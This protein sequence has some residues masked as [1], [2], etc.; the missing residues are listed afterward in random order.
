M[1]IGFIVAVIAV[2]V[3]LIWPLQTKIRRGLDLQ[4]GIHIVLGVE[5]PPE[6]E[7]TKSDVTD[8]ALEIIRNRI[9]ALGVSEP[10]IQK[11]GTD[12]IIVD[13]PGVKD[14]ERAVEIIGK[15]ALLE[16]RLVEED[17]K[18]LSDAVRG[19]TI[20]GYELL[21]QKE[22]D[23]RGILRESSPL[24][25]KVEPELTGAGLTEAYVG[26]DASG[27]PEVNLEFN[28]EGAAKFAQVTG[29]NIGRRLAIVLDGVVKSA[30]VI[31]DRIPNGRAQ[32]SGRFSMDEARELAIVLRAGALPAKVDIIYRQSVGP[33]LGKEY[34]EKS[35][36]ASLYG[37]IIVVVFMIVYYLAFGLLAD[38]AV[39]MN[40]LILLAF[41]ALFKGV[42]TL[43]GI[44]G[45]AL[46][47]GMAVDANI[48]I[49]ERIREE[50][51]QGKSAKS[52]IE[53]GYHRAWTAILDSNI[54]TIIS[55]AILFFFGEGSIKGFGLTLTI[56][57]V[58][59]LFTA[60]FVT[61]A[62]VDYV[63]ASRPV[64]KLRI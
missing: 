12:K 64:E 63:I 40:L 19:E 31:R 51:R 39:A 27:R 21:Y 47:C 8:R 7:K 14:P 15:T 42:L 37:I 20:P 23:E 24:L 17:E 33:T 32:I 16:F 49:F 55:G 57:I 22:R 13:L 48:L 62:I 45:I 56:G 28:K 5:Q 44:A 35:I 3:W 2:C 52:A 1:K 34:I 54:T 41:M 9:D 26:Y 60:V 25:V 11:E 38:F 6:S 58:A 29:E 50:L 61:K 36:R 10:I 18:K 59:N 46:T 30:P 43:P 4:G 53:A